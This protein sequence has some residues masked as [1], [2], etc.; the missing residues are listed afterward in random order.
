M[1]QVWSKADFDGTSGDGNQGGRGSCLAVTAQ[2]PGPDNLW[3]TADDVLEL[4][5]SEPLNISIDASSS[6]SDSTNPLDRV[7]GFYSYHPQGANFVFGDGSVQYLNETIDSRT[8]RHLS[9]INGGET[10]SDY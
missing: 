1:G 4:L 9:T 3:D 5:N 6:A 7:R 2:N 10:I 8:Y